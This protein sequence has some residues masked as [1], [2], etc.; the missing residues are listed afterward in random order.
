MGY[1]YKEVF[2][3]GRGYRFFRNRASLLLQSISY[4]RRLLEQQDAALTI[5]LNKY[6]DQMVDRKPIAY[7]HQSA[8]TA[9]SFTDVSS[10]AFYKYVSAGAWEHI[11]NGSI[12]IGSADYYRNTSNQ[13]IGDQREG[14][15]TFHLV[16]GDNQ[17]NAMIV[18]GF[19]C[20]ILCGTSD[21]D[22]ADNDLMLSRFGEKRIKIEPVAEFMEFISKRIEATRARVYDVRY[23][24]LKNYSI[25]FPGIEPLATLRAQ[26]SSR[27]NRFAA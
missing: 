4:G 5:I 11:R 9:T 25:E 7:E 21:H 15:C 26:A 3:P 13:N 10:A 27:R 18:S 2:E 24:D 19:N 23:T 17:L 22:G 1:R 6:V 8:L 20:G 14:T 12:Q 16:S